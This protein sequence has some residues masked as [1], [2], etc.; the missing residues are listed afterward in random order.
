[1]MEVEVYGTGNVR[2]RSISSPFGSH[3]SVEELR[4][5]YGSLGEIPHIARRAFSFVSV[6]KVLSSTA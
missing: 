4:R 1:M 2:R 6:S 3:A 5:F